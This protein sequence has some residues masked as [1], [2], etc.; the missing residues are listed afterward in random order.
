[1]FMC[2]HGG[3]KLISSSAAQLVTDSAKMTLQY[4]KEDQTYSSLPHSACG[5]RIVCII[6]IKGINSNKREKH[7]DNF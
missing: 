7:C 2:A 5:K 1:M 4:F 6:F 3:K